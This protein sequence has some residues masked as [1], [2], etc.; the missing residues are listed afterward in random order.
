VGRQNEGSFGFGKRWHLCRA[1]TNVPECAV[2]FCFLS[3]IY[4]AKILLS[5]SRLFCLFTMNANVRRYVLLAPLR[6]GACFCTRGAMQGYDVVLFILA[7]AKTVTP[8]GNPRR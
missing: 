5:F 8:G 4:A 6:G 1:K 3:C 2:G 7:L